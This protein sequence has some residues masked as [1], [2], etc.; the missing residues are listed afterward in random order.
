M[1]TTI[2]LAAVAVC[3][4]S[5]QESLED[6]AAREAE[7]YTKK[8][9]PVQMGP[10]L[11]TDSVAFDK[12]TKTLHYY[13]TLSGRA[14]TTAINAAEVKK[15]MVS[16]LKGVPSMRPYQEAGYN[17]AY[18]FNSSKHKGQVIYEVTI[19]KKDYNN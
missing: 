5:C 1:K 4:A 6:R 16:T 18:T 3:L 9:C 15:E 8:N 14:D 10:T 12:Q 2:I 13:M 17:F 19:T 7:E 11:T